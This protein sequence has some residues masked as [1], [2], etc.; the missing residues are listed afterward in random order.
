M[1]VDLRVPR[2][3]AL[4]FPFLA[5]PLVLPTLPSFSAHFLGSSYTTLG[6][7]HT[8]GTG[9]EYS[10]LIGRTAAPLTTREGAAIRKILGG[11]KNY[12][13]GVPGTSA[14]KPDFYGNSNSTWTFAPFTSFRRALPLD[15]IS[16][17]FL[18]AMESQGTPPYDFTN[19]ASGSNCPA[20]GSDSNTQGSTTIPMSPFFG[21]FPHPGFIFPQP[22][23][24]SLPGMHFP[25]ASNISASLPVG[26]NTGNEKVELSEVDAIP[27]K[28][29]KKR[30]IARK[31]PEITQVDGVKEEIDV[32]KSNVLWK[33]HWIIQLIT[34]RGEMH[35]AFSAPPKQGES[36]IHLLQLLP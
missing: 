19:N 29:S 13:S 22:F 7:N 25:P 5:L 14:R 4:P 33:D 36:H 10:T 1:L 20:M 11:K 12:R 2:L 24:H 23:V 17:D 8:T 21:K 6:P 27:T 30:R 32:S 31:K 15:R 35:S 3:P 26:F 16:Q 28:I 34:L 18:D 9:K